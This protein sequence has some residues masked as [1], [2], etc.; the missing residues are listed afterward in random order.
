MN[1]KRISPRKAEQQGMVNERCIYCEH[2]YHKAKQEP[3]KHCKNNPLYGP[4]I[5]K[6]LKDMFKKG[7]EPEMSVE[8]EYEW[9]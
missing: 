6:T 2:G 5:S 1:G 7:E 8:G 4:V 9:N 3:C